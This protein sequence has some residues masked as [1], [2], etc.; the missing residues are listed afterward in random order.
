MLVN[1]EFCPQR[2]LWSASPEVGAAGG[3]V[4]LPVV[5]LLG[6]GLI[7]RLGVTLPV[8]AVVRVAPLRPKHRLALPRQKLSVLIEVTWGMHLLEDVGHSLLGVLLELH[9]F[10]LV[11]RNGSARVES[12]F[13]LFVLQEVLRHDATDF[14][15]VV[16][17]GL[18]GVCWLPLLDLGLGAEARKRIVHVQRELGAGATINSQRGGG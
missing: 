4:R 11:A 13:Q 5:H 14:L 18:A 15:E 9:A 17:D 2:L 3:R 10:E 1:G 16:E 7:H 8:R 6:F 12:C